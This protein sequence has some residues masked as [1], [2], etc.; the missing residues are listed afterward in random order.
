V[1]PQPFLP[2]NPR[3]LPT[4]TVLLLAIVCMLVV[5]LSLSRP[6]YRRF[7]L[8]S[9]ELAAGFGN[10][11]SLAG[12]PVP[13]GASVIVPDFHPDGEPSP[14]DKPWQGSGQLPP[15]ELPVAAVPPAATP[16]PAPQPPGPTSESRALARSAVDALVAGAR[17]QAG[18]LAARFGGGISRGEVEIETRGR[19][20]VLRLLEKGSFAPG[21]TI[22]LPA[23]RKQLQD[24][25]SVVAAQPGPWVLR[26][27]HAGAAAT[28]PSDWTLSAGRAAA[29]AEV[30]QGKGG[31]DPDRLTVVA[32]G[33]SRPLV[34]RGLPRAER[35][36][37]VELVITQPVDAALRATLDMLAASH[38]ELDVGVPLEQI[39]DPPA[40]EV[41]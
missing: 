18:A 30:L 20:V 34:A 12:D 10:E 24:V 15:L 9:G 3:W 1:A 26:G 25:A 41:P 11:D 21:S 28:G 7:A 22:L 23:M 19:T 38:E 13:L 35:N 2:A 5:M 27:H 39:L 29:M 14:I 37:R 17:K 4:F 16:T 6:D 32:H 31:I 33:A 36:T 40:A 8:V